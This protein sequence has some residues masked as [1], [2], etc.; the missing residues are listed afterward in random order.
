[1]RAAGLPPSAR[2]ASTL[3]GSARRDA[4]TGGRASLPLPSCRPGECIRVRETV[5]AGAGREQWRIGLLGL[6]GPSGGGVKVRATVLGP[7]CKV[8]FFFASNLSEV[9]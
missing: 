8:L 1:M 9:A 5:A 2:P 3:C 6:V 7:Q 4:P